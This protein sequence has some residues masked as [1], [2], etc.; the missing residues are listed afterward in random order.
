[1][2]FKVNLL[3][4]SVPVPVQLDWVSLIPTLPF[5][6]ADPQPESHPGKYIS[7][8]S[9]QGIHPNLN[10]WPYINVTFH[11]NSCQSPNQTTIIICPQNA[12]NP[13]SFTGLI[14]FL[15]SSVPVPVQLDWVSLISTLPFL[16]ADPQPESHLIKPKIPNSWFWKWGN[17]Q[18]L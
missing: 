8:V 5:L 1:M 13:S 17:C 6:F 4:S 12:L 16:F 11:C 9:G 15:P 18:N 2:N 7:Q 14:P 10:C 3:P